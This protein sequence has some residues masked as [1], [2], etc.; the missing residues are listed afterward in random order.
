MVLL[1]NNKTGKN[2]PKFLGPF[3]VV[4]KLSELNYIIQIID[5]KGKTND[6][7]YI[8]RL[9]KYTPRENTKFPEKISEDEEKEEKKGP[10]KRKRG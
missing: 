1:K 7:V 5:E 4:K 6:T 2:E 8:R 10:V 3:R 9:S